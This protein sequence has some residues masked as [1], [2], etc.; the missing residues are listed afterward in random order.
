MKHLI[1]LFLVFALLFVRRLK[2][3]AEAQPNA[4]ADGQPEPD[5]VHGGAER[6]ADRHAEAHTDGDAAAGA[7]VLVRLRRFFFF[8]AHFSAPF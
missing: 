8:I 2:G 5:V 4:D 7:V 6:G 1:S 3:A